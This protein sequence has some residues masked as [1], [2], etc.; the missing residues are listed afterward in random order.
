MRNLLHHICCTSEG[1]VARWTCLQQLLCFVIAVQELARAWPVDFLAD[2]TRPTSAVLCHA[3]VA[4]IAAQL[5][6]ELAPFLV[7]RDVVYGGH[8]L[9]AQE[10]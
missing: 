7:E 9:G 1:A 4:R 3:G 8:S 10:G 2:L 6:E 5:F